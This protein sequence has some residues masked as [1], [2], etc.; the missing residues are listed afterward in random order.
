MDDE[1]GPVVIGVGL[2]RTGTLSTALALAR[3]LDCDISRIHHGMQLNKLGQ[4]QLDFWIKALESGGK[5]PRTK[6]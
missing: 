2:P 1:S 5:D 6:K 4:E 3:L